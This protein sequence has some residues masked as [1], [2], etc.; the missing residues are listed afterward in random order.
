MREEVVLVGDYHVIPEEIDVDRPENWVDDALF[1]P[2]SR[3]AYR[4][5]LGQGLT[6]AIRHL[7]TAQRV[8]T[9]WDSTH[10]AWRRNAGLRIDHLLLNAVAAARLAGAGVDRQVRGWEK[11]SDHA[12]ARVELRDA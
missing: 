11:T 7:Y 12:P 8:Y 3:Q 10:F 5:L 4:R 6:D 9:F 2:E 1:L